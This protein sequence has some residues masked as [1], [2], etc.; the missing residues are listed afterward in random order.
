MV[1]TVNKDTYKEFGKALQSFF[2]DYLLKERGVSTHTIK[3][4]SETFALFL[5]FMKSKK[6]TTPEK[7]HLSN[8]DKDC[9]CAFLNWLEEERGCKPQTRN[10]RYAAIKSFFG[11]LIYYDPTH[12]AQWQSIMSIRVK[13]VTRETLKY[14]S[15][16]GINL[17]LTQI[18]SDTKRGRRDLA[19]A[20]LLYYSAIRVQELVDL[21]PSSIRRSKPY[22]V[23]VHGKGGKKRLVPIND[24][25]MDILI[26]YMEEN[27]LNVS[28]KNMY[29]L[30][31]NSRGEKLTP[32]GITYI[33]K[34][35][36]ALAHKENPSLVSDKLTP[37]WLR[38][39]RAEHLLQ[40]GVNL[41]SIRDLLGHVSLQTTEIYA[42]INSKA[43]EDALRKVNEQIGFEQ[44][45]IQSWE[46][47]SELRDYLKSLVK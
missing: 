6:K 5:D 23:E 42:K 28:S 19:L 18:H 27:K 2:N 1:M 25:M 4:Y 46:K 33:L 38:H 12:M 7:L 30:F 31:S 36:A 43:K 10:L 34:K 8:L 14:L 47:S 20:S 44:P 35:Y 41:I 45:E 16:E 13:K 32:A 9:L 26:M 37:H 24:T 40:G 17:F 3:S 22:M 39:S 11:Y 21:M 15:I 29:P